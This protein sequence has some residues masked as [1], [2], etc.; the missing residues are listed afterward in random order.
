MRNWITLV[1]NSTAL[2]SVEALTP[3][4]NELVTTAQR[5]YDGWQQDEDGMDDELGGGGICHLIAEDLA[6][7]LHRHGMEIYTVS[8]SHE[9]HV[10]CVGAFQEGVYEIDI[11]H[12]RYE[13]GGGYTWRKIPDVE[14]DEHDIAIS[15]L[16]RDPNRLDQ[17]VD[18]DF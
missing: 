10:Y 6:S 9:V 5:V 17:Y 1:E 14:F 7:V 8:A 15:R 11:P 3:L 13:T 12:R 2:P 16:D 18:M 4:L